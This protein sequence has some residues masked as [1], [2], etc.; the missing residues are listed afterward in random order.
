MLLHAIAKWPQ[1]VTTHFCPCAL[2][3]ATNIANRLPTG[4]DGDSPL[5]IFGPTEVRPKLKHFHTFG[6][7]VFALDARPQDGKSIPKWNLRYRIGLYLGNSPRHAR[8]ISLVLHLNTAHVS[9]QFHIQHD[10]FFETVNKAD[11]NKPCKIVAGFMDSEKVQQPKRSML[12]K[13]L[14]QDQAPAEP[15]PRVIQNNDDKEAT[16]AFPDQDWTPSTNDEEDDEGENNNAINNENNNT[17]PPR[18]F[19]RTRIPT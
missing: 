16:E 11:S 2:T 1:A 8:S 6:C 10:Q 7:P 13:I 12:R 15:P 5:E 19:T 3:H 17:P 14:G 4:T 9:P 18:R